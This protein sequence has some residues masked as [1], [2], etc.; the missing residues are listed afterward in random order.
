VVRV[1]LFG[2][3]G[4][5]AGWREHRLEPAPVSLSALRT[6]LA[7]MAPRLANALT[8]P[9]VI[10]AVDHRLVR[11]DIALLDDM[12]VAFMPPMSGG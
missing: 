12:E 7:E 4:D 9:G 2:P 6:M 10:T 8:A 5:L 11:D 3:L 1:L